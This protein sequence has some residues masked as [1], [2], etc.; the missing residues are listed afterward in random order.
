MSETLFQD[1]RY[2]LRILSKNIGFTLT[3]VLAL[4]IGIGANTAIFSLV[5]TIL[6]RPLAFKDPDQLVWIWSRRVDRDKAFFSI[7]DFSDHRDQNQTLE[8]MA[9]IDPSWGVNLTDRGEPERFQGVRISAEAFQMLGVDAAVGRTLMPEDSKPGSSRVV[10][11]SYGLWQRR[12][13]SDRNLIG[14]TLTLNDNSYTVVGVLPQ[15]FIIPNAE[16]D[17]VSPLVLET[18]PRRADRDNNFLRALA[19][20][21][22]GFTPQQA[23]SDLDSIT[24]N[25]RQQYPLTNAKKVGPKVL[26]LQEELVG[27]YNLALLMILGA[28]VLV[29]L[30]TCSNLANLMLVRASA[31]RKEMAI[32][33][34]MGA[35]RMRLVRQLL[36]ESSILALLGG[37]LGLLLAMWGVKFLVALSPANLP[38]A[39]EVSIDIRVLAFTLAISVLAALIFALVPALQTSKIG[40]NETLKAGGRS[41]TG[42]LGNRTRSLL[43]ISEVALS[44]VLL[45]GAGLLV[46]SF[47]RIQEVNPGLDTDNLLLARLS[48]P[49]SSYKDRESM[50]VFYEKIESRIKVLP[51]VQSVGLA[52]VLP[53]S[54]MNARSDFSIV[55]RPVVSLTE[56]PGAQNRWVSA[57]YFST[58]KIPILEGREFTQYDTARSQDVVVIDEALARRYWPNESPVGAHIKFENEPTPRELE[59]VGVVGNVKHFGLDEEPLAT[60]YAP[61][62]QMPENL[63]PVWASRINLVTRTS[64]DPMT[65]SAAI[66]R[67]VQD[68]DKNVPASNVRTMGQFLSASVAPRRFNLLLLT[69]FA[70]A[71][72]LLTTS[73][74]YAVISYSVVQ[75]T[76]EIGL[77]MALGAQRSDVLKVVVG[78]GLKLVLIGVV[79]GL[80]GAFA[81]SRLI[82]SLLFGVS[83]VD[84]ITFA[85]MPVLLIGVALLASYNPARRATKIDPVIALR[86]E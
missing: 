68:V 48:L 43:V 60:L 41:S 18:D 35:S 47:Q 61:F 65:L 32:R 83:S 10:V 3:A 36:T 39:G 24:T 11:L 59:V 80:A 73:G 19:R 71:A 27:S 23:Q 72:L 69:V 13:G 12:F 54:A 58:M 67:E 2:G 22:P 7:A 74:I 37:T 63:V 17:V 85:V 14:N 30:I 50:K 56:V 84:P 53:L 34:A 77:R 42:S 55:G 20:L 46:K 51:G 81:F 6:L 40:L 75:R 78:Q 66:R 64:S 62:Y 76:Q 28:V 25:L 26:P 45:I 4:A 82:S 8:T 1:L 52:S 49:Q 33:S 5:N 38:R 9:A 57:G 21:K 44:L 70:A 31:R 16:T 15:N 79:T 29:L 86:A